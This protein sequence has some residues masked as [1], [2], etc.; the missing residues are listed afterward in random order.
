MSG[1]EGESV[2]GMQGGKD[3]VKVGESKLR[4]VAECCPLLCSSDKH[5]LAPQVSSVSSSQAQGQEMHEQVSL[6]T[7]HNNSARRSPLN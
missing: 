4:M 1:D 2:G 3:I 5:R 7:S 6:Q